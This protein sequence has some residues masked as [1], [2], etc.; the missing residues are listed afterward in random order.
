MN[1]NLVAVI[2]IFQY[3]IEIRWLTIRKTDMAWDLS[4]GFCSRGTLESFENENNFLAVGAISN[5]L[6]KVSNPKST[7]VYSK[8][9]IFG[10]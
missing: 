2:Y 6:K 8:F 5:I 4:F 3:L 10:N 9:P 7:K 1:K